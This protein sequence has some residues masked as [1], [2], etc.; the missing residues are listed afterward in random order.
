MRTIEKTHRKPKISKI[1]HKYKDDPL[2]QMF[3]LSY[4]AHKSNK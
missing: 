3:G 1:K 4:L 2:F